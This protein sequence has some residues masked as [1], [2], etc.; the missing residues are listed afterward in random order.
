MKLIERLAFISFWINIFFVI[1]VFIGMPILF[2][3]VPDYLHAWTA[4]KGKNPLNLT[5]SILNLVV[6]FHWGYCIWFLF[7]YDRYSKSLLPLF[8]FNALYAPIYYYRVKIKKR[9]LRNKIKKLV[10]KTVY[11]N[12]IEESDFEKLTRES[13]IGILE[14]W[15]S[16]S[17]QTD[18][19][20]SQPDNN[21]TEELFEKWNDLF[22]VDLEA[23][24]SAF[25][26]R[27]LELLTQFDKLIQD[28]NNQR[29]GIFSQ[30]SDFMET[31]EWKEL[32]SS[33]KE[34]LNKLNK[35]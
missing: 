25:S 24:K 33:A 1:F 34:I 14:L 5:F 29:N 35:K 10:D 16:K 18:F 6:V 30:L 7:K 21:V 3:N 2:I 26:A 15:S 28:N 32:N 9:P 11:E 27:E 22:V 31:D 12:S 20:K 17:E 19:Q 13:I 4:N 23:I 8:F